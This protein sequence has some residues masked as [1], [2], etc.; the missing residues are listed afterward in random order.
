MKYALCLLAGSLFS[1]G[2]VVLAGGRSA[3]MLIL[4]AALALAS[5]GAVVYLAG[6]RRV[7]RF[8]NAFMDG[9]EG[10]Q[11]QPRSGRNAN[12]WGYVKPSAKK[13]DRDFANDLEWM[14]EEAEEANTAERVQ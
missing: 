14:K 3:N 1:C 2:A 5:V 13:R 6:L 7:A 8:L 11:K 12:P 10:V 9:I 4:G